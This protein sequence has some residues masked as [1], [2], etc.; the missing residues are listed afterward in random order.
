MR[1]AMLELSRSLLALSIGNGCMT[2]SFGVFCPTDW[3]LYSTLERLR[4][5]YPL[6]AGEGCR[7]PCRRIQAILLKSTLRLAS[8]S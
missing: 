6:K 4:Y 1:R 3:T 2:V 7:F 8:V 5:P